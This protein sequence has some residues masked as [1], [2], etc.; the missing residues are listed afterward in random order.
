MRV[1]GIRA[2]RV[3]SE[4]LRILL[5]VCLLLSCAV[6]CGV[7]ACCAVAFG[8]EPT[9]AA[10]RIV[11]TPAGEMQAAP[12]GQGNVYAP[13]VMF[14]GGQYRMWFGG[15]GKDG[16]DR[17][18]LAESRDGIT[19]Q[20]RS[21]VLDHG[22]ANHVNDPSVVKVGGEYFM[23]FTRAASDVVDEIALATSDD[24][25]HWTPRGVVLHPSA[26]ENWDSLLVG[27]PSVLVEDGVYRMW[28]D[29][30]KDLPAGAP[31]K[32]AP[33]SNASVR[34]V[35]YATSHDGYHWSRYGS[36]PVFNEDAGGVH[37]A[38][39]RDGYA[40]VYEGQD[41]TH[42]ATSPDG[43]AWKAK[44]L[45]AATS[46][47]DADRF[48]HVTPFLLTDSRAAPVALFVGAA[49]SGSW[50]HNV[51]ARVEITKSQLSALSSFNRQDAK[52]AK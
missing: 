21:V 49:H 30:R 11:I 24:G 52:D 12:H 17:I 9:A 26:A 14:D 23:Y 38:R 10:L 18:Q 25:V 20:S 43:I 35:G 42:L 48:G 13:D 40:M 46:G 28:Y 29:G 50:D 33:K 44:G 34:A 7:V 5:R 15:Q 16:H 36:V 39:V 3:V 6:G 8:G 47:G 2:E 32:D 51:I 31:A 19:W 45:L 27:R 37:V 41:G 4:F 1:A 22:D